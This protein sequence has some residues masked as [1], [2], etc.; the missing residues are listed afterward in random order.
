MKPKKILLAAGLSAVLSLNA[1]ESALPVCT[2]TL[3]VPKNQRVLFDPYMAEPPSRTSP[4]D[5]IAPTAVASA[6]PAVI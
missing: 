2:D 6:P 3:D 1:Q 4:T 5:A